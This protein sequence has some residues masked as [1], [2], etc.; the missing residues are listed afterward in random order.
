MKVLTLALCILLTGWTV[1]TSAAGR[2][3]APITPPFDHLS[4]GFELDGLHRDVPCEA[5][6]LHAVFKGTP[7]NCGACHIAGS[8]YNATPKTLTHVITT[9]NCAACHD[10]N[11]F[12]PAVHFDHTE[13]MGTCSSCHNGSIAQGEG[14]THP[15]TSQSCE[16]CHTVTSWTVLKTVDHSQIP[17]AVA[18]FC[19]ICH[20]GVQASGK[21][22]GHIATNLECGDCHLTTTWLAAT[23]DH[24][25]ILKGC[26]TC[27]DGTQAVGKQGG[28]MPTT[29][30]CEN[31]HTTGIGTKSPS[32]VPSGF[33]H[34]QMSVQTCAACHSGSVKVSTGFVSGPPGNHMPIVSGVDCGVCHGNIPAAETWTVI[35]ATI[36]ALHTGSPAGNCVGCHGGQSFAGV[37]TPY[38]P[39]S[40]A[41]VSPTKAAPLSPPHIPVLPGADCSVCHTATFQLGGFGPAT[42]M[43]AAKHAYVSGSCDTCHDTGKNFY[44]GTATPLQLRPTDHM[45]ATDPQLVSGDCSMCHQTTDWTSSVLPPGHMPRPANNAC[46]VC[47]TKAP[48]DYAV[49]TLAANPI[50]HTGISSNCILCHGGPA[51]APPVFYMNYTP[52]SAV[53][54][55]VHIPTGNTPCESCHTPTVF[56]SFSGTTMTAAKHTAM[57]PYIG[58][59]C[60]ACHDA[61][62]PA[63]S[64]Y[65][66]NNLT[67]RPRG[68][69]SGKEKT[70]D[71]NGCHTP[72]D[73]G[74]NA[75]VRKAAAPANPAATAPTTAA[76]AAHA[77]VAIV[78]APPSAG[79][80][81]MSALVGAR[82]AVGQPLSHA[83]VMASC[84][85]C[86]NGTLATGKPTRHISSGDACENC[87]T[88]NG[89]LPARFEHQGVSLACVQ[90][91]NDVRV[92]GKPAQHVPSSQDCRTCHGTITWHAVMF[93][94]VGV[95]ANCRS[96]HT[97]QAVTGVP[98]RHVSTALDCGTC[99]N[100]TNW[101]VAAT[102]K[103]LAPLIS[104]RHGAPAS[105]NK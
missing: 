41:G 65:G 30:L 88:T 72:R 61:V 81:R 29:N 8:T 49:A 19:I 36:A 70:N 13:V 47:H 105:Q 68:H 54:T 92:A 75:A 58:N 2:A 10:T 20:N 37:P 31:C 90:C 26:A 53:L 43:S 99:H 96:C 67:T 71:C 18:G 66:V 83:G 103:K 11:A 84:V 46:N 74:G 32:W 22:N 39:I 44:V 4:T 78:A 62:T 80:A 95:Q 98:I 51:A 25:G 16:A 45:T 15:A 6:H 17:L 33:D 23:F 91:H 87:H 82:M 50:L 28:H 9:N 89:W 100:T 38:S 56:T 101:T 73:W 7:R 104:G 85:A 24:T 42:A 34:T 94:H 97:G 12:R 27:H 14:P 60:D 64:F 52:K 35:P 59:T 3:A 79:G 69:N 5:C 76:A 1:P 40:I 102:P 21:N 57:V 86:H 63:L 55:P 48:S 93:N 77:T